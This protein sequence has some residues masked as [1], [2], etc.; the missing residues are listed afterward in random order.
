MPIG[1]VILLGAMSK[2]SAK[3]TLPQRIFLS[4]HPDDI[5][6]SCYGSIRNPPV[7]NL[8]GALIITV[9]NIGKTAPALQGHQKSQAEISK[10]RQ[11]ENEAFA[12]SEGCR[13]IFLDHPDS[14]VRG[15]PNEGPQISRRN[16]T[17]HPIFHSVKETIL[18]SIQA[19]LGHA[20]I[21][22]PLGIRDHIDH[23]I[24]RDVAVQI[25]AEANILDIESS[26]IY[27][28]DLPYA[29]FVPEHEI[30]SLARTIISPTARPIDM[31]L[32]AI[33]A[34]KKNALQLYASQVTP[35]T[36]N[37]ITQYAS[38]LG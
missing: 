14:A 38:R 22:V 32:K 1:S 6:Y 17:N 11:A 37:T 30:R 28:E 36:R 20:S 33:W 21:F 24:V 25:I 4:P 27:Y 9:F 34:R 3:M 7:P 10:I 2:Q 31:S 16:S 13:I 29:A 5:A 35:F 18:N 15:E 19:A 23:R 26:L 12:C 8:N